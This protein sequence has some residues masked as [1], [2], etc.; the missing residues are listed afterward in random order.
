M[1]T[2]G[3]RRRR[4]PGDGIDDR[5]SKTSNLEKTRPKKDFVRERKK[6]CQVE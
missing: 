4:N 2:Y 5:E 1:L 6:K 3:K